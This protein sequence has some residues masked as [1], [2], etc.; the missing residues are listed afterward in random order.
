MLFD[1]SIKKYSCWKFFIAR[2]SINP[3]AHVILAS[4]ER[5]GAASNDRRPFPAPPIN[6]LPKP[7][8]PAAK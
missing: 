2:L 4:N 3:T 7:K 8:A 5:V 1:L 6:H